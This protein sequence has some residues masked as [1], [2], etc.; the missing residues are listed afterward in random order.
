VLFDKGRHDVV[1]EGEVCRGLGDPQLDRRLPAAALAQLREEVEMARGL[2]PAFD[3]GAY[4]AGHLTPVYFGSALNNFGVR[5]LLRGLTLLAPSPRP[6]PAAE[7]LVDPGEEQV[8]GFVFK[9]QAN[10]DPRH[11]DR[12]AFV[13]LCSGRFERAMKLRHV[14]SGK[15]LAIHNPLLFLARDRELAE[16]AFAGDIL[17]IPNH[18]NL[19]I[20]DALT[21]GEEL[22]FTGIPSFAPELL[23]KV[24]PEDPM[25]A[26]HLGKALLHLAEEG[27][28]QV[29]RPSLGTD[30]IVGV[31]G[32][33]QFDVLADRI[34]TEYDIPVHFEGT[35]LHTARWIEAGDA[36]AL[37]RFSHANHAS[38]AADHNG[39]PVFLAR[40]AWHLKTTIEEWPAVRFLKTKEQVQ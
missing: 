1:T 36:Q 16:E 29:F 32:A 17:G 31:A 4:R 26:K 24:R 15:T 33:L 23:R 3:L 22:H 2:C 39:S 10:M 6:Q 5:E 20:G 27:A 38:M 35:S 19:R 25:R 12:V 37:K 21:E 28:A 14:R 13:R 40:N 7:R 11:R 8:S 30:W 34:R 18:G 9:I